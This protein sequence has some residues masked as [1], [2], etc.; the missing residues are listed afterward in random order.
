MDAGRSCECGAGCVG[1][2]GVGFK[3]VRFR[4]AWGEGGRKI[5]RICRIQSDFWDLRPVRDSGMG[6]YD[7]GS[8]QKTI[9]TEP[10]FNKS[11]LL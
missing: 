5:Q 8:V 3:D 10:L 7:K 2:S 6:G 1:G 4:S 9:C 11:Q